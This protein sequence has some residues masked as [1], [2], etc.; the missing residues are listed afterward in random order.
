MPTQPSTLRILDAASTLFAK[1]GFRATTVRDIA[2]SAGVNQITVFRQFTDK[3]TLSLSTIEFL[4]NRVEFED[5]FTRSTG[6]CDPSDPASIQ[7]LVDFGFDLF[8]REPCFIQI[9]MSCLFE[10]AETAAEQNLKSKVQEK[11]LR[12][13]NAFIEKF[14]IEAIAKGQVKGDSTLIARCL[15]GVFF[16]NLLENEKATDTG[17]VALNMV[18]LWLSGCKQDPEGLIS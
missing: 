4:A 12:P 16:I 17:S 15:Q 8:H 10:H 9:L 6:K 2:S 11:Y 18:Q 14:C 5:R 1:R 3:H 7:H 13:I